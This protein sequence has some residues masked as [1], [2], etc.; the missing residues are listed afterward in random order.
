MWP[1]AIK[2]AFESSSCNW[3]L[4]KAIFWN[5]TKSDK[6]EL[7]FSP[8][9]NSI[10]QP[11]TSTGRSVILVIFF[12]CKVEGHIYVLPNRLV[13][14]KT[15]RYSWFNVLSRASSLHECRNWKVLSRGLCIQVQNWAAF[16]KFEK[17]FFKLFST[18]FPASVRLHTLFYFKLYDNS[19][20]N[21]EIAD[22]IQT[23]LTQNNAILANLFSLGHCRLQSVQ[24]MQLLQSRM[25]Q[26][27]NFEFMIHILIQEV[28]LE[29][30][31]C[32]TSWLVSQ[33]VR[34]Y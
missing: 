26:N 13:E 5:N 18:Q 27:K 16:I 30:F 31:F 19:K 17:N 11:D 21:F 1:K 6:V 10:Y 9:Q 7:I 25:V 29:E 4:L 15:M 8:T 28:V 32:I 33:T 14:H 22:F 20:I 2:R 3:I 23:R 24:L 34:L 12:S